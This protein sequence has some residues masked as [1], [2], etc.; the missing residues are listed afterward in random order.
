P[1]TVLAVL[2]AAEEPP[3]AAGALPTGA[4]VRAVLDPLLALLRDWQSDEHLTA[5]RLL[6]AA[7]GAVAVRDGDT[8]DPVAAAAWGLLRTA[9]SENPDRIALVD[10]DGTDA[11]LRALAADAGPAESE[12]ALREGTW[13]TPRLTALPDAPGPGTGADAGT[14]A[15]ARPW[16]PDGTV[17]VTGGTGTLG[18]LLARRLVTGHGVRHLLLTGRRG[19]SAPGAA[20]LAAELTALG[21]E[22]RIEA[23]DAG[24]R[25]ALAALLA[26]IPAD[27]PLTA[28]VHAAGVLDDGV[29]RSLTP[30][31]LDTVLSAKADA[32]LHLHDLTRELPLAAF[33]LFSSLAGV[34]GNAGQGNYAAANALLDGLAVRRRAL[35]L[36]ALSLAWGLWADGS[37]LT[38]HLD[39]RERDRLG[40]DGVVPLTAE[41]GLALLDRALAGAPAAVVAAR[42]D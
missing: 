9:R 4:D 31:R 26:G 34:V 40:R 18:G 8:V 2:P 23:C 37:A 32:A 20:E 5:G 11:S 14:G 6:V 19:P 1:D 7:R 39:G 3:G 16:D 21:A 42:L 13:Y 41:D 36:P 22:V 25:D 29:V 12:L 15:G 38:G 33:V 30:E 10:H 28:V 27:R 35:G 24:D 17:L